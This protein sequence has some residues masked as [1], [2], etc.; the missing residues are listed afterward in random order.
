M[1]LNTRFQQACVAALLASA[2]LC[3]CAA[4]APAKPAQKPN[5]IFVLID[6]MGYG[7]LSCYGGVKDITP[8]IDSLA[9]E[10]VR[11]SQFYVGAPICSP[12]RVAFT[13]GQR[14]ARWRV[15][16]FLSSRQDNDRRGMA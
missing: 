3:L 10:G 9:R 4:P 12:S 13:T 14:P 2:A 16:S 11:F 15:T 5:I 6:D 7:D 1:K 8:N